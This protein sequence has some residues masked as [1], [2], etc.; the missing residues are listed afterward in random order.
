[1][2]LL[3]KD[4]HEAV[5]KAAC[6]LVGDL[7]LKGEVPV[8]VGLLEDGDP[9]L[10]AVALHALACLKAEEA[11]PKI[12]RLLDGESR[13]E[14]AVA[15]GELRAR[16]SIP[17]V[18]ALCKEGSQAVFLPALGALY[19]L[20]EKEARAVLP[21][22]L[23]REEFN[24][25]FL[26]QPAREGFKSLETL[27][28]FLASFRGPAARTLRL[29]VLNLVELGGPSGERA[30][31]LLPLLED[32][33]PVL[34]WRCLEVL[35]RIDGPTAEIQSL[36]L[37]KD[38]VHRVRAEAAS[39]LCRRGRREGVPV[40]L[41]DAEIWKGVGITSLNRM[42]SPA[43]WET[44]ER[45]RSEPRYEGAVRGLVSRIAESAGLKVRWN[46]RTNQEG[47]EWKRRESGLYGPGTPL[48]FL[49]RLVEEGP[50][51]MVLHPGEM[52]LVPREEALEEW[53]AWWKEQKD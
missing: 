46:P 47:R 43:L 7:G 18:R 17:R 27:R 20:D 52:V 28:E 10:R 38:P 33:D 53:R 51:E 32:E 35:S 45:W 34:R 22:V 6:E 40:L 1:V 39:I 26:P 12:A 41:G 42:R 14:A 4:P 31:E 36:R 44:L 30:R 16:E 49:L 11:A 15:L 13:A 24:P 3:L 5:R 8:L 23:E 2:A 21:F 19:Q 9:H 50:Y 48:E 37:L 29:Q 25:D